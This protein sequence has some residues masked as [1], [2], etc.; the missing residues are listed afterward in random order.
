[1]P[2]NYY[3]FVA[4]AVM[5]MG[6]AACGE[7]PEAAEQTGAAPSTAVDAATQVGLSTGSQ[8]GAMLNAPGNYVRGMVGNIDKAQKAAALAG[9]TAADRMNMDPSKDDGN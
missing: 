8:A 3:K 4:I 2:D 7:K 5:A 6:L 9:K 1:M